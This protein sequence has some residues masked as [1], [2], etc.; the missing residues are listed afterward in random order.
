MKTYRKIFT[1][2]L[3]ALLAA[4]GASSCAEDLLDNPA[5]AN[6]VLLPGE[7]R[8]I[9]SRDNPYGS[10]SRVSQESLTSSRFETGDEI[11]V[12][13]SNS[14]K[15][16]QNDVFAARSLNDDSEIQVLAPPTG[17]VTQGLDTEIPTGANIQY[18]FYYPMNKDLAKSDIL[19]M[20][21]YIF[22]VETDQST[23]ENYEKSDF[24]WNYLASDPTEPYQMISMH[25]LMANIV[26]KVHRDSIDR[27]RGVTLRSLPVTASRIFFDSKQPGAMDYLTA[28]QTRKDI[29]MFCQGASG[30]YLIYRAAVPAYHKVPSGQDIITCTLYNRAGDTEEVT[31]KLNK[32][33]YL[34]D[35]YY[36]T[37]TL[38]SGV[39]AAVP[40]VTDEDSWVLDVFDPQN[41]EIVGMLCREYLRYQPDHTGEANINSIDVITGKD[42]GDTK[43]ISS[44]AWV[45]YPL[46]DVDKKIPDLKHGT[47]LRF[48]YDVRNAVNE[49]GGGGYDPNTATAWPAPHS[50][51]VND[52]YAAQGLFLADHGHTWVKGATCGE[53]SKDW[54]E[55]YMHGGTIVWEP[56]TSPDGHI[57]YH[58]GQ[59]NMPEAKITNETAYKFGH[60][61]INP[62]DGSV[63]VSYSPFLEESE[64]GVVST[65]ANGCRVA[66]VREHYLIDT[67]D[68]RSIAYP[69]VKIGFN[70]FWMSKSLRRSNQSDMDL[71]RHNSETDPF[72]EYTDNN[73]YGSTILTPGYLYP[74]N[75]ENDFSVYRDC[76][77]REDFPLLYN[78]PAISDPKFV[79]ESTGDIVPDDRFDCYLPTTD[80]VNHIL[81][82]FGWRFG[83]KLMT[84]KVITKGPNGILLESNTAALM[85]NKIIEAGYNSFAAN[86]SGFNFRTDGE[87]G[88]NFGVG[89][90]YGFKCTM[91]LNND[92]YTDTPGPMKTME[93]Q[94][95]QVFSSTVIANL[96]KVHDETSGYIQAPQKSRQFDAVRFT[97]KMKG[98]DA[99]PVEPANSLRRASRAHGSASTT[100]KTEPKV[101]G[102]PV[103][104]SQR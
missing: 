17:K 78:Y 74:F 34:L 6:R 60:I 45:Y 31:F 102:I 59:F 86:V 33:L 12:F 14:D 42:Y 63:E 84:S 97:L 96:F 100:T 90:S 67:D 91:W 25:H 44:Q 83:A 81:N 61:A 53:S 5:D 15:Q 16:I 9:I 70:N 73:G 38:Q 26:V 56:V 95:S 13:A 35:G 65:D 52:N 93:F 51:G 99:A 7:Y 23:K 57:Y 64:P 49:D 79:P 11:G 37:F 18:L 39:K 58:I 85:N 20:Y 94:A 19:G 24:L 87:H 32:D 76:P 55:N 22:S 101:V 43:Y 27:D 80:H 98:Q 30:E 29:K 3:L 50:F 41:D 2:T 103:T 4:A 48:I 8:F 89:M 68:T 28:T 72:Q 54:V 10:I 40:D 69:L 77:N 21:G 82:Y 47:V 1:R 88:Y 71:T 46:K 36:Y 92:Y 75:E 104:R 62:T 66:Y